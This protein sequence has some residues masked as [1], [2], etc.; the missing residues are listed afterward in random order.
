MESLLASIQ[1]QLSEYLQ[2]EDLYAFVRTN[3]KLAM[4]ARRLGYWPVPCL[5]LPH[6]DEIRYHQKAS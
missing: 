4:A 3:R 2:L 6:A 1:Q 5:C